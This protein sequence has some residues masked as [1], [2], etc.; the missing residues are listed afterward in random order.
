[1]VAQRLL[2]LQEVLHKSQHRGR[3]LKVFGIVSKVE[4]QLTAKRH[5]R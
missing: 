3:L 5:D 1:M 4:E 2:V